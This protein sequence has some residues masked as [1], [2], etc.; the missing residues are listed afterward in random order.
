MTPTRRHLL[1]AACAAPLAALLACGKNE[2][3]SALAPVAIDS[4]TACDLDGMLLIDY[5][6]PKAQVHYAGAATPVFFCDTVELF[7]T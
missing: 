3:T 6:G 4:A 5:P 7:N 2:A 1:L